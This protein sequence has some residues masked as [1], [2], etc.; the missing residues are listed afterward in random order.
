MDDIHAHL[1]FAPM[2]RIVCVTKTATEDHNSE[3]IICGDG[4]VGG[5]EECDEGEQNSEEPDAHCRTNCEL[6]K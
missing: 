1:A 4:A 2:A 5:D 3:C 6:A